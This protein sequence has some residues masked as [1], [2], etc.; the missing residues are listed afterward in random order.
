MS[1]LPISILMAKT[2]KE[3]YDKTQ[4]WSKLQQVLYI[5]YFTQFGKFLVKA[6]IDPDSKINIIQSDFMRKLGPCISKT[7]MGA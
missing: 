5:Y 3:G 4:K 6:L 2:D 7:N 1:V